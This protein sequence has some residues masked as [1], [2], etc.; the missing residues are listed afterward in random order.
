MSGVDNSDRS[1]KAQNH[2]CE[3]CMKTVVQTFQNLQLKITY[4][5][6]DRL[7]LH[8]ELE[9]T[10]KKQKEQYQSYQKEIKKLEKKLAFFKN[11]HS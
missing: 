1:W 6:N 4:L 5:N 2:K 11:D 9:E 3:Q 10:K 8:T 7:R